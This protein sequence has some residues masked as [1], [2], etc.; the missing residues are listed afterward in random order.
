MNNN[1]IITWS[2]QKIK[3]KTGGIN[4]SNLKWNP[5]AKFLYIF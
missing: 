3:T 4:G 2:T 1:N 5:D